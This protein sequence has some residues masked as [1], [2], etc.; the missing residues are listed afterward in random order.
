M[1]MELTQSTI[2]GNWTRHHAYN[3]I[4][5]KN[6]FSQLWNKYSGSVSTPIGHTGQTYRGE[7][8]HHYRP[9]IMPS[10]M[11]WP[12]NVKWNTN[13]ELYIPRSADNCRALRP[14][15][16]CS[17]VCIAQRELITQNQLR[18]TSAAKQLTRH[19]LWI[20]CYSNFFSFVFNALRTVQ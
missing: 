10:L 1:N 12:C 9:P 6:T 17:D 7:S 14:Q 3:L 19:L 4:V 5:F 8:Y 15:S 20:C 18:N 11:V 2:P 16:G 13:V